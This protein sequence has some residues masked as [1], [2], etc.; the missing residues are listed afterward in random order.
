MMINMKR[1]KYNTMLMA[2]SIISKAKCAYY[3]YVCTVVTPPW[4][5]SHDL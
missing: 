5:T 3:L 4:R 2:V 1:Y